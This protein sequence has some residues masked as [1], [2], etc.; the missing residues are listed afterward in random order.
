M[1]FGF[2]CA[3]YN[4]FIKNFSD[5]GISNIPKENKLA[6][7]QKMNAIYERLAEAKVLTHNNPDQVITGIIR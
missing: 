7:T 1:Y 2:I 6:L 3:S 5:D 4:D